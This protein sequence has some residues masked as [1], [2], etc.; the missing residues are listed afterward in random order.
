MTRQL[1][2]H[3]HAPLTRIEVPENVTDANRTALLDNMGVTLRPL[4]P[5]DH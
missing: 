5:G 2:A 3:E 4:P 1:P